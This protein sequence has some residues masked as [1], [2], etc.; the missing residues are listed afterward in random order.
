[1]AQLEHPNV[2]AV[3]ETDHGVVMAMKSVEEVSLRD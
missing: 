1:M 3:D 2:L